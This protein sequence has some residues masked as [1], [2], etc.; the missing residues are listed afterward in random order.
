[1]YAQVNSVKLYYEKSG[2][3]RPIVLL[4]GN[5]QSHK[6]FS[7]VTKQLEKEFTVYA[8]D[9]RDHGKSSK[10]K[11]L[12]YSDMTLDIAQFIEQVI[13]EKTI[14]YGLS[15]GGIIALMLAFE[16]PSFISQIIVSGASTCPAG[17]K[18]YAIKLFKFARIFYPSKMKMLLTQPDIT[19]EQ[20]QR[21]AVPATI[22]AGSKDMIK[23]ENTR[24]IASNIPG[25]T[26]EILQ[27]EGHSSYAAN[28]EK[29]YPILKKYILPE[30]N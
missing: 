4:H 15:D 5:T 26:L 21:I 19:A 11:Q 13:G 22:L 3:G 1:M 9:S 18:D 16:Y 20:L 10:V 23:E 14:V 2:S 28:S 8:V 6:I 24:F 17:S 30:N 7:V 25:S 27:G 12:N 29:L